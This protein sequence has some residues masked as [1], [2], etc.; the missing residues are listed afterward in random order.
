MVLLVTKKMEGKLSSFC[1]ICFEQFTPQRISSQYGNLNQKT[2]VKFCKDL[3]SSQ[4]NSKSVENC[5]KRLNQDGKSAQKLSKFDHDRFIDSLKLF[6]NLAPCSTCQG[7]IS[8]AVKSK[9][10]VTE[11]EIR[12]R[13]LQHQILKELRQL[14]KQVEEYY[15][16]L[17]ILENSVTNSPDVS[18]LEEHLGGNRNRARRNATKNLRC[19]I[20]SFRNQIVNGIQYFRM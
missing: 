8:V 6:E 1:I 4:L 17:R 5:R 9:E 13:H 10:M 3:T 11:T 15:L 18:C 16:E 14:E 19:D 2:F 20:T 7:I 12:V